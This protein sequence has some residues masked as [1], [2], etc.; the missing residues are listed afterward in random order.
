MLDV[1]AGIF[2]PSTFHFYFF[3]ILKRQQQSGGAFELRSSSHC[4]LIPGY[5]LIPTQLYMADLRLFAPAPRALA[6]A[7]I[8]RP[9]LVALRSSVLFPLFWGIDIDRFTSRKQDLMFFFSALG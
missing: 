3:G 2:L 7:R 6:V 1:H 9:I 8:L 5:H 4:F